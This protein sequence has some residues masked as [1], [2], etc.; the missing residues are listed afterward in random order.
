MKLVDKNKNFYTDDKS[1]SFLSQQ[2][3]AKYDQV[4]KENKI[5]NFRPSAK[6]EYIESKNGAFIP[7]AKNDNKAVINKSKKATSINLTTL[8]VV[9][10]AVAGSTV[11]G[12]TTLLSQDVSVNQIYQ[13]PNE[14]IFDITTKN[15]GENDYVI[16]YLRENGREENLDGADGYKEG[17]SGNTQ[18]NKYYY[19]SDLMEN[20]Q[21]ILDVYVC[22]YHEYG[23]ENPEIQDEPVE[24]YTETKVYSGVYSTDAQYYDVGIEIMQYSQVYSE[25]ALFNSSEF[26]FVTMTL[27]TSKGTIFVKDIYE[28]ETTV[29]VKDLPLG[30]TIHMMLKSGNT[31]LGYFMLDPLSEEEP[32]D[33]I[34]IVNS[35]ITTT[36]DGATITLEIDNVERVNDLVYYLNGDSYSSEFISLRGNILTIPID[37][38]IENSHND[39]EVYIDGNNIFMADLTTQ[40]HID[41]ID[42]IITFT[43][44]FYDEIPEGYGVLIRDKFD[45][46]I[47]GEEIQANTIDLN[48]YDI[49]TDTYTFG[50]YESGEGD[51]GEPI[52]LYETMIELSGKDRAD[53]TLSYDKNVLI[54]TYNYGYLPELGD[55]T[56][57]TGFYSLNFYDETYTFSQSVRGL[58]FSEDEPSQAVDLLNGVVTRAGNEDLEEVPAG[59][60]TV[61]LL[62]ENT[63]FYRTLLNI[64]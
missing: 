38:L 16:T 64:N 8:V 60:Y 35:E 20:T 49:Y 13:G 54:L 40:H 14:M 44:Y 56:S 22:S 63:I 12:V 46:Y 24:Q 45:Q 42:N 29:V 18:D 10:G 23:P 39:F 3:N 33:P 58:V 25:F 32:L 30:E 2:N 53:F 21:Y 50:V 34:T 26:S 4:S 51:N 6:N 43:N 7:A 17:Y 41:V 57:G 55:A 62:Y 27:F 48:E 5:G 37:N 19:F 15:L 1:G 47:Y 52:A 36:Y 28:K 31:G 9:G 59:Q 11:V 61:E